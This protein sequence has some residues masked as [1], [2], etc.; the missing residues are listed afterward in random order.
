[1]MD[2]RAFLGTMTGSL[3]AMPLAAEAQPTEKVSRIGFLQRQR[4]E[5]VTAFIQ[6]LQEAGYIEGRNLTLEIRIYGGKEDVLPHFAGE[7]VALR[8]DVIVAASPYAVAAAARATRVIPIVGVDLES[9]PVANGWARS[10]SRPGGNVTGEFLDLPE[11]GG[12][13]IQFL[14][15]V[16]PELARVAVLWDAT[17]G[18]VQVRATEAAARTAGVQAQSLGIRLA[19]DLPEAFARAVRAHAQGMI[20]LSSPI[21]LGLREEISKL[22]LTHHLPAISLFTSYPQ[23]GALMAYGPNLAEMYKRLAIY[24]DRILKGE[25]PSDLPIARPTR[26]ELVINLKAAKALG[27]TI[28]QSLLQ[29]AD[30]V[31][32]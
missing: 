26:F 3:L 15:E 29:R 23:A 7:L 6:G 32:E 25:R 12:K 11:L 30:Q 17:I 4:N 19:A 8:C 2:R 22:A 18:Q 10:L 21:L 13:Q 14:R 16:V 5:N 1:M 28:S 24:V 31:I 27:L 20:V 9:D